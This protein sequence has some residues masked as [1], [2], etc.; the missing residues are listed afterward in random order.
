MLILSCAP[1]FY[2]LPVYISGEVVCEFTLIYNNY[3]NVHFSFL[4]FL[5]ALEA[6]KNGADD[7]DIISTPSPCGWSGRR[8]TSE[9]GT[10][11]VD[12]E[13]SMSCVEHECQVNLRL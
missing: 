11:Y 3:I 10:W 13:R 1:G 9:R 8:G 5:S 2:D 4:V 7:R 6:Q 12:V